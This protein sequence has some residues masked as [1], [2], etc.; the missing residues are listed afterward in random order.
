MKN[1]FYQD[2]SLNGLSQCYLCKQKG[3]FNVCWASFMW[4]SKENGHHYCDK[5]KNE[6]ENRKGAENENNI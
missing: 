6:I 4:I 2:N 1:N 5:C 3:I